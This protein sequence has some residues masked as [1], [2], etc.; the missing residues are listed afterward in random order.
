[1][2]DDYVNIMEEA[3][4]AVQFESPFTEHLRRYCEQRGKGQLDMLPILPMLSLRGKPMHLQ[5]H[6]QFEPVYRLN[7]PRSVIVKSARQLGKSENV[8]ASINLRSNVIPFTNTLIV[9]PLYLQ[10]E[11]LSQDVMAP[12]I[13]DSPYRGCFVNSSC[14]RGVLRKKYTNGSMQNFSYAF[15]SADRIRGLRC[16][17][18]WIDEIQDMNWDLVP[19]ILETL[20]GSPVL[21]EDYYSGSPKTFDNTCEYKWQESSQ[22][23]WVTKCTG[24]GKDN[25][26]SIGQ[27]LLRM[28]G[29]RGP[30][31]AFCG[32]SIEPRNGFYVHAFP[33][34]RKTFV[35]YHMSQ[36]ISPFH[37]DDPRNWRVL[38]GKMEA[39]AE[40]KFRNECL[41]E[42]AD[43]SE[44]LLTMTE[45]RACCDDKA[46]NT[47]EYAMSQVGLYSLLIL[48]V[49]WSGG[50]GATNSYTVASCVGIR[51]V[52]GETVTLYIERFDPKL[53][54]GQAVDR[55]CKLKEQL[56]CH[57]I[58]HDYAGAG[59]LY[60]TLLEQKHLGG[61]LIDMSYE[62]SVHK[63]I[64]EYVESQQG[65]R[66]YYAVCKARALEL[67]ALVIKAKGIKFPNYA[68]CADKIPAKSDNPK[69]K[70]HDNLL[71]DFE[72]LVRDVKL[73]TTSSEVA[74]VTKA[75]G[76]IDDAAHS[77]TFAALSCWYTKRRL[78]DLQQQYD[79]IALQKQIADELEPGGFNGTPDFKGT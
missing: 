53:T 50:G 28:I 23:E 7:Q 13:D 74:I 12:Q 66:K 11:R 29:K 1:M 8:G 21:K 4:V 69:G 62:A 39:Y 32:K 9:T 49:D 2:Q 70:K 33:E 75:A 5:D 56:R 51:A 37:Y 71:K 59:S 6:I 40:G 64:V 10:A 79:L 34:R 61:K 72:S 31:C 25:I 48:G 68:S 54:P 65:Y 22:A 45:V 24:C 14:A 60:R 52:D 30:I 78:P 17:R 43:S 77:I 36:P 44:R 18:V 3:D 19:I 41:G 58:A 42:S 35:G 76:S 46:L 73:R 20:S 55:V 27:Q 38:L 16:Q 57:L 63:D 15:L 26:A 47:L 67:I